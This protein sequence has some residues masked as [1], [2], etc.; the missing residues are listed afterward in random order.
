MAEVTTGQGCPVRV[1]ELGP[2]PGV[3]LSGPLLCLGNAL[4]PLSSATQDS[5]AELTG[6]EWI[7]TP[8][9]GENPGVPPMQLGSHFT[10][11]VAQRLG[12]PL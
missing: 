11:S 5:G 10:V 12:F 7:P 4:L 9:Q 8:S 6:L 1:T 2:G 3:P